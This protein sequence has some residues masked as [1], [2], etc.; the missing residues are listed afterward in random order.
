VALGTLDVF[1]STVGAAALG[2]ARRALAE[3]RRVRARA[4]CSARRSRPPAHAGRARGHGGRGGRERAARVPRRVDARP[5][6]ERVTR[7]AAMAKLYATEPRSAS[8][9]RGA[10][11]RR[12]RRRARLGDRAALP[13][14]RA[15]RIYEGRARSQRLVIAATL[16]G[17]G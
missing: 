4:P 7:E 12:A 6:G 16:R 17:G 15:L 2:F 11:A 10:A 1:R 8:S 9:T 14:V 3:A 13:E 5:R